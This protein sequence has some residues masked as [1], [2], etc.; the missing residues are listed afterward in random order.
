MDV[1]VKQ[2][3]V[4]SLKRRAEEE[5]VEADP[6]AEENKEF[7]HFFEHFDV[8]WQ[9]WGVLLRIQVGDLQGLLYEHRESHKPIIIVARRYQ[10]TGEIGGYSIHFQ[11]QEE[12][13]KRI[14]IA[15]TVILDLGVHS[16]DQ[17]E[18]FKLNILHRLSVIGQKY[19]KDGCL[20]GEEEC[21]RNCDLFLEDMGLHRIDSEDRSTKKRRAWAEVKKEEEEDTM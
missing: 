17:V 16:E 9:E 21:F 6:V 13:E 12:K 1:E 5:E 4:P 15:D 2:E 19:V 3:I 11:S 7:L 8:P 10:Q 14:T 18:A 20:S